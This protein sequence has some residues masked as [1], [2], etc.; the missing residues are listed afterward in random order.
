LKSRNLAAGGKMERRH[1]CSLL[2]YAL[3][4]LTL[5]A[6]PILGTASSFSVLGGSTVTNTGAT[7]LSG[8]LGVSPGTA[9]TGFPPGTVN[10]TIHA[11]DAVAAQAQVDAL[12]AY[13]TL[14]GLTPTQN[15]TGDLGSRTLTPGVYAFDSSAGLTGQL[16]L[17]MLGNSNAQFVFLIGST[18]TTATNSSVI[19]ANG[20]ADC[21]NVYWVVGSSATLG[22]TT[23]F[24]GNILANTSITLNTGANIADGRALALNGAVTLD[25]NQISSGVCDTTSGVPEPGTV[26]LLG[27]GLFGLALLGRRSRTLAA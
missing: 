17:D 3:S 16:T 12:T 26:A 20:P 6:D 8:D 7:A 18:L 10:G 22:T 19:T 25:T 11:G 9:I 2:L 23:S 1:V 15:L 21:C 27:A 5:R 24:M 14:H 4:A 13:N